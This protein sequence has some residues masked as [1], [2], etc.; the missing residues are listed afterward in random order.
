MPP[1]PITSNTLF[2]GDNL[3]ILREYIPDES[4]DLVYLDPPFNSNRNYNVLFKDESGKDS[5]AQITA[6]EDT[7]HWNQAA[8]RT[9]HELVTEG[10]QHV[11]Q[12]IGAL[13]Q[14]I[15]TN[16]MMAYLVMMAARLVELH[17]VLKP[18][19]SMYLHCDPTASHYLKII[20]DTIFRPEQFRAEIIW[21]RTSAH[22][23]ARRPGPV[24]D[25]LHFYSKTDAYAWNN[26]Y[27]PYE[28]EYITTFFDQTDSNGRR[29]KRT[30]LT[31]DGIRNGATGQPWRGIDVTAK[32][33]HWAQPPSVL[34]ALDAAGRIHWP[35]KEGGMPRLKQYPEDL[36]GVPLQDV[37]TDIR[38]I[39]NLAG[40]RLG[41]PTQKPLVLLERIITASSNPNDIVLD[42]FCG[43]G[44]AVAAAQKLGRRW[45]GIDITHL[46][47]ALQKYRLE[48]MFPGIQFKVI[49][50]PEDIGAA[51]QL[52]QDDRYQF[53][54]W[55][56]S[57]VRARPLGG[58]QGNKQGKKGSDRGIDGVINF[59]DDNTGKPKQ[60]LIQVK[61][62][63]VKA[64]DIRDLRGTIEREGAAIGVFVTLEEP[65][66]EM[67]REATTASF[68]QSPSWGR[69][70]AKIQI[71][72]IAELLRG[73]EIQMPPAYG[74]FKQAQRVEQ[75]GAVQ[76]GL[77]FED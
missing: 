16:Q 51:H 3:D 66:S 36:P 67:K 62:G 25:V 38:P 46:S 64:G 4:I 57:L 72:T 71:L 77:G 42:P 75:P 28:P 68:Y 20:L 56:L 7:W 60:V 69:N 19:G 33:R 14:F 52:A 12:M 41:Y 50:E 18:T 76:P 6:F 34:D 30:D 9:Y 58:E 27:Q 40:E 11:S 32:G 39:H 2:Y 37:W 26:Q 10:P 21:K 8:E 54:W 17:R 49:G 63:H 55:A 24:H 59:I 29:W 22:S 35:K 61:S 43:C 53:Q 47:I 65:S 44:T 1:K 15:G 70:Y 23:S 13:R 45:I 73:A 74:T 48:H 5:E 31:G